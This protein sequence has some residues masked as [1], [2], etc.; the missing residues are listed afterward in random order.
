MEIYEKINLLLQEKQMTKKEF[1]QRFISL[2]PR[3]KRTGEVLTSK[4]VY[5]YLSGKATINASFIPYM[6]EALGVSEQYLF[7]DNKKIRI[8]ILKEVCEKPT[9]E[10]LVLLKRISQQEDE[11]Y[12]EIC[13]KLKYAPEIFLKKLQKK[14]LQFKQLSQEAL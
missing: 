9:K 10:E 2:E 6:A 8:K 14:L 12:Q 4:V 3:S 7:D 13:S 1:A 11:T 5:A